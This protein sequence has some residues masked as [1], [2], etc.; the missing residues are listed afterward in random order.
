[1][2]PINR[3][4]I[5]API[6]VLCLLLFVTASY[7]AQFKVTRVS[8][9]DTLK[10]ES[11][12]IEITVRLVGIDAPETS[13]KKNQPGQPFSKRAKLHLTKMVLNKIVEIDG[14]GLDRYSRM[15]G[16]VYV[17]EKNVNLELIKQGL[18]EVYRGRPPKG[19]DLE[20]YWKAEA[21]AR[22][23]RLNMWSLGDKYISP[24]DWRKLHK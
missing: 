16:V 13:R 17:D 12:G 5:Y 2:S 10:A 24:K 14:Y 11:Q 3:L 19:L 23:A 6:A 15:L 18:A 9:G 20:T 21:E 8:D 7:A 22:E 4:K 1:M